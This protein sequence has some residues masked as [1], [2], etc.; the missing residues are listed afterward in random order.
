[1]TRR[2]KKWILIGTASGIAV[3]LT[4]AAIVAIQAAKRFDPFIREQAI[5]YLSKRFNAQVELGSLKV[6]VPKL[7]P[8]EALMR[9]GHGTKAR[10]DGENLRLGPS[11]RVAA[12]DHR[13]PF[14]FHARPRQ[15]PANAS[16]RGARRAQRD[17]DQYSTE[18]G[19]AAHHQSLAEPQP[20]PQN[21]PAP[22]TKVLIEKVDMDGVV[23][24]CS[25]RIRTSSR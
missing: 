1:M 21:T 2:K 13:S 24:A 4:A 23:C 3:T 5:D 17:G 6:R 11:R 16:P 10:V 9:K 18:S 19:T 7:S 22:A 20:Q 12:P 14:L 25:R 8:L 15:N